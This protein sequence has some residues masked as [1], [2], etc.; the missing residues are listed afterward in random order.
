MRTLSWALCLAAALP[1]LADELV[2]TTSLG[3]VQGQLNALQTARQ[4]LGIPYAQP[5]VGA[6]RW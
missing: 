2:V 5:P 1:A 3:P 4:F 6:L